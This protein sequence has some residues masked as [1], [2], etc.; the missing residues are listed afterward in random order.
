M[1]SHGPVETNE[2]FDARYIAYFNRKDIDSWEFR[3]AVNDLCGMDLVMDPKIVIAALHACRRLNDYAATVRLLEAVEWSCGRHKADIFPYVMQ[4]IQPTLTELGISTPKE[5]GYDKPE[6]H[7]ES[8]H[9][10]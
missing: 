10:L 3:K 1:S 8:A 6:L 5:M 2:E 9:S 4:E 7:L